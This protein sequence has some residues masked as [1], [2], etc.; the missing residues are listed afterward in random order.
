MGR[1]VAGLEGTVGDGPAARLKPPLNFGEDDD[2][3]ENVRY[4]SNYLL[5]RTALFTENFCRKHKKSMKKSTV[6]IGD[7]VLT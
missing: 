3:L 2:G 6:V 5:S 7:R 4:Y 1:S